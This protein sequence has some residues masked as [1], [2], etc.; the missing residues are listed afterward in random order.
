MDVDDW[1]LWHTLS[2]LEEKRQV[3]RPRGPRSR[4]W[5]VYFISQAA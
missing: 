4:K 1:T 5:S 2:K 3:H